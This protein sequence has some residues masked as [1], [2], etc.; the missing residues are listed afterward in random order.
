MAAKRTIIFQRKNFGNFN[1]VSSPLE[2][3]ILDLDLFR[4][5]SLWRPAGSRAVYGGQ[6]CGQA[7][8]AS[9][10]CLC[11]KIPKELHSLHS[12]FMRPGDPDIPIIYRVKRLNITNNFE[13]HAIEANQ[14]GKTIFGCQASYQRMED[15][16]L[17]HERS[18]PDAPPP[19][20]LKSQHQLFQKYL[21]DPTID[22]ITKKMIENALESPI[23]IDVRHVDQQS[24]NILELDKKAEARKL[25][26][27]KAMIPIGYMGEKIANKSLLLTI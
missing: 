22:I 14:L 12:Y 10:L 8:A 6:V 15:S 27:M 1:S 20:T 25:V 5:K 23:P 19:E 21:Q 11:D 26:W 18:M 13:V 9:R 16:S 24:E 2:L 7:L 3:E 17:F 4:S